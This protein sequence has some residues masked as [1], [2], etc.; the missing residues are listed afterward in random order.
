[1]QYIVLDLE[2]NQPWPGS[3]SSKKILPVSIH[4]EIIQIGAVRVLSDQTVADEFQILVRAVSGDEKAMDKMREMQRME[5]T[6][7]LPEGQPYRDCNVYVDYDGANAV[8]AQ[9][10]VF[11]AEAY[12]NFNC[13]DRG[14]FGLL[15][16]SV[17]EEKKGLIFVER[18]TYERQ[19]V[20]YEDG[21]IVASSPG[22]LAIEI[23]Y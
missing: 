14:I 1:M 3:P 16:S 12:G 7:I 2:W 5:S 4:G 21:R 10:D 22:F 9:Q 11:V 8:W 15:L 19:K 20:F 6:V 13:V 17:Y 23:D 18:E